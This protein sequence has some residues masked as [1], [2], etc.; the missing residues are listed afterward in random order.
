ML[1]N[2]KKRI[3]TLP[4][5]EIAMKN[6]ETIENS[7]VVYLASRHKNHLEQIPQGAHRKIIAKVQKEF[8]AVVVY[9]YQLRPILICQLKDRI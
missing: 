4:L 9:R 6:K 8:R 3:E 2:K 5:R 7:K 1:W